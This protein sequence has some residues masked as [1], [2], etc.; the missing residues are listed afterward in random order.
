MKMYIFIINSVSG[1]GKALKAWQ[2]IKVELEKEKVPY[3]S[4]FTKYAGHAEE[5][6]EQVAEL[7][8]E[9]LEAIVAVGGDGTAHEIINGLAAYPHLPVGYI[10]GGSG[11]DFARGFMIPRSPRKAWQKILKQRGRTKKRYDLGLYK[12]LN[13]KKRER[14]FVNGLG[15]GFD[16]E[17]AKATNESSYKTFL[18]RIKCG[19]LAYTISLLRLLFSYQRHEVTL[20]I[21]GEETHFSKVWLIAVSNIAFYGGGMKI[22]P[23]AKP[24]DGKLNLC[25]VHGIHPLQL[26][27]VFGSV[28]LG[29]H[30]KFRGVTLLEG[31]TIKVVS[32]NPMTIHADGEIIGITPISIGIDA[33]SRFIC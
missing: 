11:N 22:S 32:E 33:K 20:E 25:I 8:Q 30:H 4:F 7:H 2:Q 9:K 1:N 24:N 12:L 21:D 3:R 16:G 14:F 27:S 13:T 26:L 29:K 10:P 28:F 5:I 18:N 6:A 17:V 15:I 23:L 31:K 19:G